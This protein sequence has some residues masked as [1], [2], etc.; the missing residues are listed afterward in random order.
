MQFAYDAN[1]K[2]YK[3]V[4]MA[5]DSTTVYAGDLEIIMQ[6]DCSI[7]HRNYINSPL[8][9][10]AV[11]NAKLVNNAYAQSSVQFLHKDRLGSTVA[12]VD[13]LGQLIST[14]S[15]DAFGKP[16][17]IGGASTPGTKL[18]T[19]STNRGF[20]EHEHLDGVQMIH[21]NGRAY[22]YHLGP[23]ISADPV[24]QAADKT[25]SH[26]PYSYI[27]NNPLAGVDPS[28]YTSKKEV[29]DMVVQTDMETKQ[30]GN[31]DDASADQGSAAVAYGSGSIDS[32]KVRFSQGH[33]LVN[34]NIMSRRCMGC[35]GKVTF[36]GSGEKKERLAERDVRTGQGDRGR[37][38]YAPGKKKNPY[39]PGLGDFAELLGESFMD[40]F[41]VGSSFGAAF[42]T[43]IGISADHDVDFQSHNLDA[44]IIKCAE[45]EW[46]LS[47]GGTAYS[48]GDI[49]GFYQGVEFKLWG[50]AKLIWDYQ[51]NWAVST[52]L[53]FPVS[54]GGGVVSGYA[55]TGQ[56]ISDKLIGQ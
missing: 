33:Q 47:V 45:L 37:S 21:M 18:S 17:K 25:Q 27:M 44:E 46:G 14:Q 41:R 11:L 35:S 9:T 34:A 7:Q 42:G 3:R 30:D 36:F 2:R 51:G 50:G 16:R 56:A 52:S 6:A 49:E 22:D 40:N 39:A 48:S 29:G 10:V 32:S 5:T 4:D 53:A 38:S 23:F 31:A 15:F 8:G 13:H 55:T 19:E 26:N 24:I 43:G 12:T 54:H 1:Y 28:G 20:T